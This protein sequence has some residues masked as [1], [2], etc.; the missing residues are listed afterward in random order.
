[1]NSWLETPVPLLIAHRGASADA[2]E[3]TLAAFSLAAD[4]GARAIEFD[5]QLSADGVPVIIHDSRLERTTNGRGLVG[6]HTAAALQ[7]LDAGDGQPVPT[8]DQLFETIGRRLL[9]N[10]EIKNW[11]W[12]DRGA[13]TAIAACIQ[14]H[15]LAEYVLVSSFNPWALRRARRLLPGQVPLALLY[16]GGPLQFGRYLFQG[17]ADHPHYPLVDESYMTWAARH[18]RRVHVWTV[19]DPAEAQRLVHLGVHGIISNKPQYL[20]ENLNLI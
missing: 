6:T 16:V 11:Q 18:K 2:P 15:G 17:E 4:Q 7:A 5:V 8:L 19:D 10:L 13:E 12:R 3:N 14:A 1:L 20:R 9:Y